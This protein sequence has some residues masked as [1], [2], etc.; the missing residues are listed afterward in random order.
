MDPHEYT[1]NPFTCQSTAVTESFLNRE[2]S[3]D[4]LKTAFCTI[5]P[6][7][8]DQM[9]DTYVGL[10]Y[11]VRRGQPEQEVVPVEMA[12]ERLLTGDVRRAGPSPQ[13]G[14]TAS[15]EGEQGDIQ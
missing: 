10:A 12:L 6:T 15:F 14:S 1:N 11:Q 5:N 8:D 3:A 13:E 2:V 4:D 7:I 9:L